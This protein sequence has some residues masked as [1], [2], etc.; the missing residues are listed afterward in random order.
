MCLELTFSLMANISQKSEVLYCGMTYLSS[1]DL[2]FS[3]SLFLLLLFP[4]L[5]DRQRKKN[6]FEIVCYCVACR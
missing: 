4:L 3:L 1:Q 5:F 6:S 2:L